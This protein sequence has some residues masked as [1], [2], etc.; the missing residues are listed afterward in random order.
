M[1]H[2]KVWQPLVEVI[3][4]LYCDVQIPYGDGNTYD[5][6]KEESGEMQGIKSRNSAF[7]KVCVT[8]Y[9]INFAAI[10]MCNYNTRYDEKNINH[11]ASVAQWPEQILS[12]STANI[13][14][15]VIA[16]DQKATHNLDTIKCVKVKQRSLRL[17]RGQR[18][19]SIAIKFVCRRLVTR[20]NVS[21]CQIQGR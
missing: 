4:P 11:D 16:D 17:R 13:R 6:I 14:E 10:I 1:D 9:T 21:I 8:R 20:A 5:R 18:C 7:Y 19:L 15:V 3:F 12:A 2:K